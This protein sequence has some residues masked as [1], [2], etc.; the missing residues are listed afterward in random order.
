MRRH[1][2]PDRGLPDP[3]TFDLPFRLDADDCHAETQDRRRTPL[4]FDLEDET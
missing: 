4:P 1:P 3:E 2:D